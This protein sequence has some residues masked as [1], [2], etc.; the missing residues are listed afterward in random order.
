MVD[1]KLLDEPARIA[2]LERYGVLDT[3]PEKP[4][5][6][7]TALVQNVLAVPICAVSLV[8]RDRQWF[9]SIQG[10]DAK[11]TAVRLFLQSYDKD[12]RSAGRSRR[13]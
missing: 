10:L 8:D 13:P 3:P 5:D 4:F 6:K 11:E 9:K 1:P 2:A 7:I 12:D